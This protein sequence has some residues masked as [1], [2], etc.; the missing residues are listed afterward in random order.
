MPAQLIV[1]AK[2]AGESSGAK[3]EQPDKGTKTK[4]KSGP[5]ATSQGSGGG[6]DPYG[7]YWPI[8]VR[9]LS[10]HGQ[11]PVEIGH[12]ANMTKLLDSVHSRKG[13]PGGSNTLFASVEDLRGMRSL[14]VMQS[15]LLHRRLESLPD[16]LTIIVHEAK[17]RA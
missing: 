7:P 1:I 13:L 16:E 14:N 5:V 12:F 8:P 15:K 17:R 2:R 9:T 6:E 11:K 3:S 4:K 10:V